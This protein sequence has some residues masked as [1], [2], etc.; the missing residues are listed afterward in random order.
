MNILIIEDEIQLA[1][2]LAKLFEKHNFIVQIA[3]NGQTGFEHAKTNIY[4]LII[5]DVMLPKINGHE[6]LKLLRNLN[7]ETPILMLTALSTSKDEI[8]ALDL[9]ADD[10]V[11]KP[12]SFDVLMAHAKALLRRKKTLTN[13][14]LSYLDIN[15]NLKTCYLSSLN[16]EI[17]LSNKEFHIMQLLMNNKNSFLSKN[18]IID[19]VWGYDNFV[20]DNSVEVYISFLRKKLQAIHSNSQIR[21][22]RN[23]G[24]RLES[25][26]D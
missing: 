26:N 11:T 20:E 6:L 13:E 7:I 22:N 2:A 15:L 14:V 5:L 16:N 23:I 21:V 8:K 3:T 1:D 9:G 24:Y 19:K 25:L 4:D 10:Y 18:E 12:Y 17:L